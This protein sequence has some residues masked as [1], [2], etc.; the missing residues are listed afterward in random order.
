[1]RY[2]E[3]LLIGLGLSMDAFAVSVTNG[4]CDGARN[5][6]K[7][8]GAAVC[9]GFFQGLMPVMG[10]AAGM[11]FARYI[12]AFDH[13]I[14]LFLLGFIGGNM[15][16]DA[17]RQEAPEEV[18]TIRTILLQGVAVSIDALAVGVSFA[19]LPDVQLLPAAAIIMSIPFVMSCIGGLLGQRAGNRLGSR[20]QILGGLLLIG[21]GCKIFA[22]HMWS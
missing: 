21:I 7:R 10:Y 4:L 11:A 5:R 16:L 9:F 6:R 22:E 12:A 3:I 1:M 14:A 8:L 19:A 17:T 20:A 13:W 18:L 15:L 2:T